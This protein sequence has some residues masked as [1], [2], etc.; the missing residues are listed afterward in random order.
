[1]TETCDL[2]THSTF[3]DGTKTPREI[4]INAKKIGLS[5]V[6]LCDHN[7]TRGLCEFVEAAC[8]IGITPVPGCEFSVDYRGRELHLI[9]MFLPRDAYFEIERM[10]EEGAR[11]KDE[12]NIQLVEALG[13]A[14]VII[15]YEKIKNNTT[16]HSPNRAHIAREMTN[17]GYTSSVS[18]AFEKYLSQSAGFYVEPPR[19]SVWD[20][21]EYI[22]KIG[23]VPILAHPL[24]TLNE[25]ELREFLTEA[26]P[27]GLV[28]MECI[29]TTYSEDETRLAH[30]LAA[31][32]GIKISGGSD[33]HGDIKPDVMLGVGRG[34]L[35]VPLSVL[36]DLQNK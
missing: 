20:M 6:A 17:L 12:S 13:R 21:M 8:E 4:V 19:P 9:G 29:Y 10:M 23:A 34:N 25:S 22:I 3:S 32:F 15:D 11:L 28:A 14:G 1:M 30:K 16:G 35:S 33:Y 7:T 26:V 31:E 18:E 36:H 5:A 2:H 24:L 27:R